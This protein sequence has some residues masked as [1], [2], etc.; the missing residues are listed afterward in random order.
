VKKRVLNRIKK[1]RNMIKIKK[2][3]ND[4][5]KRVPGGERY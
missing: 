4:G 1:E 2:E 3:Q 5:K